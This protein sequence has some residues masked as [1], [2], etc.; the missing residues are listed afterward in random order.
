MVWIERYRNKAMIEEHAQGSVA[1]HRNEKVSFQCP[2]R[3]TYSG[4]L[5]YAT[6]T[7]RPPGTLSFSVYH[8]SAPTCPPSTKAKHC[9]GVTLER[10]IRNRVLLG[11]VNV[12]SGDCV[13]R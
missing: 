9:I 2:P 8:I 1:G 6:H 7:L 12:D 4:T 10:K 11:V 5:E 13:S 3:S